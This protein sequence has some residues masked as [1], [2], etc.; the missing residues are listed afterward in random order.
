MK[1]SWSWTGFLVLGWTSS[2]AAQPTARL[3]LTWSGPPGCPTTENVQARIDALLGGDASASSVADVRASG[4]V[5]R[6]DS[7]YKLLLNMGVGSTPSSRVIEARTCDEL[8]GAAA[9]AIALLARSTLSG[10][11][12]SSSGGT[13]SA[14]SSSS[15]SSAADGREH[16]PPPATHPPEPDAPG[17]KQEPRDAALS[18]RLRLVLDAPIGL[19]GWGSQPSTQLGL[20]G[21]VGARWR[22]LR[23]SVRGELWQPRTEQVSGFAT[24]FTL[25]SARADACIIQTALGVEL[26]PCLGAA[27]QRLTGDGVTSRVFSAKSV[28]A[29]WVSG[30]VGLFV[31]LPTPGFAHL[32]FFGDATVLV[33]PLRPRFVIDQLGPVH[34]PA[35]AAPR[36]DL[37]CEWIF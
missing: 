8:A 16:P 34:E 35:L 28:T 14:P 11:S 33:S 17:A 7:G 21:A 29:T 5:E 6:V 18:S 23:L 1:A 13:S 20:A 36:V 15:S 2:V 19:A 26:G 25:R 37:G 4:Q 12:D 22:A 10:N 31:S 9:I 24:R 32:R 27:V 3:A 30:A